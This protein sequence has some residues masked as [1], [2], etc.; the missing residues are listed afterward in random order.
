MPQWGGRGIDNILAGPQVPRADERRDALLVAVQPGVLPA[1]RSP[2]AFEGGM[3]VNAWRGRWRGR[4]SH[5]TGKT[6]QN[7]GNVR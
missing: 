2:P 1:V 5:L 4:R 6:L 7:T 3:Y